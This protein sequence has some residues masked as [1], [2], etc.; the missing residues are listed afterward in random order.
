VQEDLSNILKPLLSYR[1]R[2]THSL[3]TLRLLVKIL[4]LIRIYSTKIELRV[5]NLKVNIDLPKINHTSLIKEQRATILI[6]MMQT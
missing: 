4:S 3:K 1:Q 6:K 2:V 5:L